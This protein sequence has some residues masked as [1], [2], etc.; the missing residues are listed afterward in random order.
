VVRQVLDGV[1]LDVLD[2]G[3]IAPL[4]QRFR[5]AAGYERWRARIEGRGLTHTWSVFLHAAPARR[6][7]VTVRHP[8][9]EL[10]A[11]HA[12]ADAWP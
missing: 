11:C 9:A 6:P 12:V 8:Q 2:R 3:P 5:K 7:G 10:D 1:R 4:L